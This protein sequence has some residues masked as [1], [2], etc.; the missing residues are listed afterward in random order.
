[1]ARTRRLGQSELPLTGQEKT[2]MTTETQK[3]LTRAEFI[4]L[5]HESGWNRQ[6]VRKAMFVRGGD[7]LLAE[8]NEILSELGFATV[9]EMASQ[10]QA[11][12]VAAKNQVAE[13]QAARLAE[14][15]VKAAAAQA[16]RAAADRQT[17]EQAAADFATAKAEIADGAVI[18][19]DAAENTVTRAV[20]SYGKQAKFDNGGYRVGL[21]CGGYT[22]RHVNTACPDQFAG[23]C[24]AVLKAIELATECGLHSC[25]IRNDRIGGFESSTKRGYAGAKYLWV[26]KKIAA[27]NNLEVTFDLCSGAEN[28]A[29][30]ASRTEG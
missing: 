14:G 26:A 15:Q 28:Q 25:T 12:A 8:K 24:F 6:Q 7:A 13:E 27:E 2:T 22:H 21:V 17:R 1:M 19:C 5:V 20:N 11:A 18:W 3:L 16:E 10:Q 9:D 30:R 23:E 4:S 29:D